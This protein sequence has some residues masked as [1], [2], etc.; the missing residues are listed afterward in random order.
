[1]PIS[2]CQE[3]PECLYRDLVPR[4]SLH[5]LRGCGILTEVVF[6]K[7]CCP[8]SDIRNL[9]KKQLIIR[10]HWNAWPVVLWL[11]GTILCKLI[12]MPLKGP[13]SVSL[14][15][16]PNSGS[17]QV[18]TEPTFADPLKP[19]ETIPKIVNQDWQV[20]SMSPTWETESGGSPWVWPNLGYIVSSWMCESLTLSSNSGRFLY[21]FCR[22]EPPFL[23]EGLI[24]EN[25]SDFPTFC[26]TL[27]YSLSLSLFEVSLSQW[28]THTQLFT[29]G[30]TK[31]KL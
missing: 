14:F 16:P 9:S 22:L 7:P 25:L 1:M 8:S 31:L 13:L 3:F 26:S 30:K 11:L 27:L 29:S 6:P 5:S 17:A 19:L 23:A 24:N 20:L 2:E 28:N 18:K 10:N 12:M 15:L 4:I 21:V